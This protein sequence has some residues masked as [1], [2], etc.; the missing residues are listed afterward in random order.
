MER[1]V[2]WQRGV[3][4]ATDYLVNSGG[5]IFAAQ[6][7]LITT[8]AHLRIP[9]EMLGNPQAVDNWLADHASELSDLAEMRRLAGE[10]NREEVI[11]RNMR[12]LVDLLVS[13]SDMLPH[14]A[15]ETDQHPPNCPA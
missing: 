13:D 10:T 15:A 11:Q 5:V 6:E 2:Y 14:E 12:E 1:S 9:A 8:P 7:R 3:L 4:I